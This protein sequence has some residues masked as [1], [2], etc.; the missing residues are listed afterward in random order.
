MPNEIRYKY[1]ENGN[2]YVVLIDN[3]V[4]G[5]KYYC[6]GCKEEMIF[7]NG[8]IR[9]KHFSHK[10]TENCIGGGGEGYLHETFSFNK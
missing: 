8:Q 2:G 3:A 4:S 6:S 7:K 9:Q 1:A 5:T 10:N